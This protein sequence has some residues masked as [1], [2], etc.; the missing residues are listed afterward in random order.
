M[1]EAKVLAFVPIDSNVDSAPFRE[2]PL[3][4]DR[5]GIFGE[6]AHP[7]CKPFYSSSIS[8][9]ACFHAI[10]FPFSSYLAVCF[11]TYGLEGVVNLGL[12]RRGYTTVAE[13]VLFHRRVSQ[14]G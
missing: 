1:S 4:K 13:E 3:I 12:C 6:A 10:G 2:P 8:F 9:N 7:S 14:M 5:V 11:F